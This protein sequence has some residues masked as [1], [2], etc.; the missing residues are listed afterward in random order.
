MIYPF[1]CYANIVWASTYK[2]N[3]NS[4]FLLQNKV[5]ESLQSLAAMIILLFYFKA[6]NY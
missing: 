4:I 3:L 1:I 2:T 6:Y 5:L